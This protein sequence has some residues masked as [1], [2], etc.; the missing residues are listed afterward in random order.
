MADD[1]PASDNAGSRPGDHR[2]QSGLP[3]A[4]DV[5]DREM[6]GPLASLFLRGGALDVTLNEV[7]RLLAARLQV[8][9]VLILE[10]DAAA[11]E[12]RPV[13]DVGVSGL[14]CD[15]PLRLPVADSLAGVVALT[16]EP[17]VELDMMSR[18]VGRTL[19]LRA[20]QARSFLGVPM[21]GRSSLLGVLLLADRRRRHDFTWLGP[22]LQHVADHLALEIERQ[23]AADELSFTRASVDRASDA[24][25]WST[26]DGRIVDANAAA[27]RMLGVSRE[28]L[29]GRRVWEIDRVYDAARMAGVWRELRARRWLRFETEH[30]RLDGT[31]FPVEI[32]ANL[33]EVGGI[34]YN[35]GFARD[36]TERR[37]A[38]ERLRQVR[39]QLEL[40]Q[41][42]EA[43][44]RL[45]G[46]VAHDFNNLLGVILGFGELMA[47]DL[48]DA[49]P[50]GEHLTEIIEAARR[51]ASLASQLLAFSRRQVLQPR[52]VDLAALV[53]DID[54]LLRR[55]I[56]ED[57]ELIVEVAPG[58]APAHVDPAQIEQVLMNLAINARDAMPGGGTLTIEAA[59]ATAGEAREAGAP[60]D[61]ADGYLRLSVSDTGEGMDEVTRAR[62]FEPFFTTKD[63]G[64]GL[65]LSTVYGVIHQT[66]GAIRVQSAPGEGSRFDVFLP[67]SSGVSAVVDLPV[68]PVAAPATAPSVLLVEDQ[69]PLRR[70]LAIGLRS[71]GVVVCEAATPA[72]ALEAIERTPMRIDVLL[73]D[74]VMPGMSG[75]ELAERVLARRQGV[76]VIYMS[77]Y[78]SDV[79]SRHGVLEPAV[80]LLQKP[81]TVDVLAEAIRRATGQA[82]PA[83]SP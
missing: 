55:I 75:R 13:G 51:G 43:I 73:T 53:A 46:G 56:G 1:S 79:L 80:R 30:R 28:W 41:R 65:G 29:I 45:A 44:G 18:E 52:A 15:A 9:I 33:V 49:H 20:L 39:Q 67:R 62:V 16:G 40:S 83:A 81:F 68:E 21:H 25:Y 77:G 14:T 61:A 72:L 63:G 26:E 70:M 59:E 66:G 8:P 50:V 76:Q 12:L 4:P 31:S 82:G 36:I 3:P 2:L 6:I 11:G 23:R 35:L 10:L 69:E 32:S 48:G 71:H 17:L 5:L 57:I 22:T 24:I 74:V 19:P 78:P 42:L 7:A 38:E 27:C 47:A 37:Q 60:L 64:T 34:S 58:L 54:R